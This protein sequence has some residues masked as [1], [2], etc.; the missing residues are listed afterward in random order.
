MI[1][2]P[3]PTTQRRSRP[4]KGSF[5]VVVV[6]FGSVVGVVLV[7]AG[8]VAFVGSLFSFAGE[9]PLLDVGEVVDVGEVAVLG[10]E[11]VVEVGVVVD[12][13]VGVVGVVGVWP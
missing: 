6:A 4:V 8:A 3:A 10:V 9:V 1:S 7:L 2:R 11:V 5:V 12:V 13:V